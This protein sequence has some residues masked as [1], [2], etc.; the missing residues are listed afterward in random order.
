MDQ[1]KIKFARNILYEELPNFWYYIDNMFRYVKPNEIL[2]NVS[3]EE[4]NQIDII[5]M[6][7]L[8]FTE[9]VVPV[10][11]KVAPVVAPVISTSSTIPVAAIPIVTKATPIVAKTAPIVAKTAV[12]FAQSYPLLSRFVEIVFAFIK[13]S[14]LMALFLFIILYLEAKLNELFGKKQQ[15]TQVTSSA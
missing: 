8:Q 4:L 14:L 7:G 13:T 9:I 5:K 2:P 6:A 11:D 10:A 3:L 1:Q 15:I 12:T